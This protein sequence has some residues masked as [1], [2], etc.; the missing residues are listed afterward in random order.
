MRHLSM[1]CLSL[2]L[3]S[4]V[5][6]ASGSSLSEVRIQPAGFPEY[7]EAVEA[8]LRSGERFAEISA[9][10]REEARA[11]LERMDQ[12]LAGVASVD[13]LSPEAK[14]DLFNDQEALRVLLEQAEKDSRMICRREK[15]LGSNMPRSV[16]MTVAERRRRTEEG[17]AFL[18][19]QTS[20]RP[21]P[22]K[23]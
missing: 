20:S 19:H 21:L 16:C 14:V 2:L 23:Q 17:Q 18:R 4:A 7:R 3:A 22:N 13:A 5:A 12:A 6:A 9:A 8:E 10:D 15:V 11:I 1:F